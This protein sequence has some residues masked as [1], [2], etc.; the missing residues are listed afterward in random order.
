MNTKRITVTALHEMA[1]SLYA[2]GWRN[3]CFHTIPH[4]SLGYGVNRCKD[5]EVDYFRT[6]NFLISAVKE[7]KSRVLI[8]G[9]C[10][11]SVTLSWIKAAELVINGSDVRL[12]IIPMVTIVKSDHLDPIVDGSILF[13]S[14]LGISRIEHPGR[15][16]LSEF[17]ENLSQEAK[18]SNE[19]ISTG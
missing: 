19:S 17:I 12:V 14:N 9:T 16:L 1:A 18:R 10:P 2:E 13:I 8:L 15:M 3:G 11:R 6:I 7:E 5:T 4:L